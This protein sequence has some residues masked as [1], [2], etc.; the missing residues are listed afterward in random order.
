MDFNVWLW[1]LY[2]KA[3][4][5]HLQRFC[6]CSALKNKFSTWRV[7]YPLIIRFWYFLDGRLDSWSRVGSDFGQESHTK[8]MSSFSIRQSV[9]A[10]PCTVMSAFLVQSEADMQC[11]E[12]TFMSTGRIRPCRHS[13]TGSSD[14]VIHFDSISSA[15]ISGN[16]M[17]FGPRRN[18][19]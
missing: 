12:P 14:T 3:V 4:L 1:H 19:H 13:C 15:S 7:H 18:I 6:T 11:R 17:C 9:S 8:I 5:L 10:L 16:S 2:S